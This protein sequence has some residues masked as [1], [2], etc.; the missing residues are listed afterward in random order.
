MAKR[1]KTQRAKASARRAEKR[2]L[3]DEVVEELEEG[4]AEESAGEGKK[5]FARKQAS[6]QPSP[7]T[8]AKVDVKP[9]KPKKEPGRIATFIQGV[10]GEIK[11][12]TWP[13]RTD[14]IRWSGVVVAALIFFGV[15]V[16]VLDNWVVTPILQLIAGIGA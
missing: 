8:P 4:A 6:S 7:S 9:A 12:V 3:V 2:E 13:S 10:R 11:R 16:F 15:Y 14:V 5:L 1:S